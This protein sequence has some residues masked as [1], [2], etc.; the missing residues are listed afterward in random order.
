MRINEIITEST[1]LEEGWKSKL[2]AAALAGAAMLGGGHTAHAQ[3]QQPTAQTQQA[4]AKW[5]NTLSNPNT[6][7]G[8]IGTLTPFY[9]AGKLSKADSDLYNK[10]LRA[11]DQERQVNPNL[12]TDAI[13]KYFGENYSRSQQLLN[14][15][16]ND[17]NKNWEPFTSQA[18]G[19]LRTLDKAL[20]KEQAYNSR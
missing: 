2:G 14:K 17:P 3:N 19:A 9:K 13:N 4:P 1:D 18:I 11:F 20:Q 5:N 15:Y 6:T 12:K 10:M 7:Y 16:A 8:T